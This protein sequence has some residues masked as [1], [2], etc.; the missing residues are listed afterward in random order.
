MEQ[1]LHILSDDLCEAI[2]RIKSGEPVVLQYN[3]KSVAA[4]VSLDDL[5][6]LETRIEELEERMDQQ[7]LALAERAASDPL[8]Y[9]TF[10]KELGLV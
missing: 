10:R 4:L 5:R 8:P 9:E 2:G 1:T 7:A 6:L 3:G